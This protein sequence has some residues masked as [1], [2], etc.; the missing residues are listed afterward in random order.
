MNSHNH[1]LDRVDHDHLEIDSANLQYK[2]E[3][4]ELCKQLSVSPNMLNRIDP[5]ILIALMLVR[6]NA[7][8]ATKM[9][10]LETR[11]L[12]LERLNAGPIAPHSPV[13]KLDG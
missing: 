3:W 12:R 2:S 4:P 8:Y 10:D 1:N 13:R 9:M 5:R 7:L 11:L 6:M